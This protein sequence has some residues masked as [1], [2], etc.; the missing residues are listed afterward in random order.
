[1][2]ETP[3]RTTAIRA[4]D[5][6]ALE[7]AVR[8]CLPGLLRA[9]LASGLSRDRAE[10][11]VQ[12]SLLVF[13]QRAEDYDGRARVCSWIHGILIR[14]I[15]EER[16]AAQRT[17]RE[18]DIDG[19]VES[20]FDE[21]GSWARPP[22]GPGDVLARGEMRRQLESCLQALPERQRIAFALRDVEGMTT[23]EVCKILE[24]SANNLGVLLFRARNGL[25]EC[26]EAKG[27]EG[28]SDAE[29]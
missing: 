28:S 2:H 11:A 23:G 13:V 19:I 12:A 29:L 5:A 27:F 18:E 21:A 14:K 8:E 4:R 16:R 24:V 26:L 17:A 7:G 9:A 22:R 25:R 1:M 20:R 6:A 10:D 15:L 3:E